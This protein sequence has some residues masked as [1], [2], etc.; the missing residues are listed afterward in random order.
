MKTIRYWTSHNNKSSAYWK[1]WFAATSSVAC[2]L[3]LE[4]MYDE[5]TPD[6][7]FATEHIYFIARRYREFV[8]LN[9][10]CR[11]SVFVGG[12]AISPDMNLFDYAYSFDKKL[13]NGDRCV[14]M[15]PCLFFKHHIFTPLTEGCKNVAA[16][17]KSKTGFCNFIYSNPSAH[18]RRDQ[19]FY[20]ISRYRQ[21]D[22]LGPHLNNRGNRTSRTSDNW[23]KILVEMKRPYKFSIAA[24]NACYD[25]YVTEKLISS[26]QA[27]TIPIYWGSP[28]VAE[29]FN[30]KAFINA[31]ELS[32]EELI[33]TVK[34]IDAND[35]LWCEM[36]SQ[37]AMTN[38]QQERFIV[39]SDQFI[40]FSAAIFDSRPLEEKKRVPTGY[41]NDIYKR[42]LTSE[43]RM[44]KWLRF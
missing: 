42:S 21:V 29:E 13:V 17:L 38:E 20:A 6:Y 26:F 9:N 30:P 41:W 27:H 15:P 19:L 36:A 25:G 37:P 7:L 32:D 28:S 14:R 5:E 44:P 43:L 10:G 35:N 34:D 24:E 16:E 3:E 12:E 18:P 31:N 40:K 33:A 4:F 11:V 2:P 22:S 39:E 1:N 8:R 23:R